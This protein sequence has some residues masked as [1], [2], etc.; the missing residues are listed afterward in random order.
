M[1]QRGIPKIFVEICEVIVHIVSDSDSA[2]DN[3]SRETKIQVRQY[4]FLK[5]SKLPLNTSKIQTLNKA[6]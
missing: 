4:T 5:S 6:V 1:R 3:G 2:S